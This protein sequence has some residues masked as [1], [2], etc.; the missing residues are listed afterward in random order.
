MQKIKLDGKL[1][2]D[3]IMTG[4]TRNAQSTHTPQHKYS[5]TSPKPCVIIYFRNKYNLPPLG[6]TNVPTI[7]WMTGPDCAFMYNLINIHTDNV[8]SI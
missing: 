8:S 7:T 2:R 5:H 4:K 6:R 3:E 1:D